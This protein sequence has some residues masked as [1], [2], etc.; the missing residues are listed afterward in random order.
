M[1]SL[2]D[3]KVCEKPKFPFKGTAIKFSETKSFYCAICETEKLIYDVEITVNADGSRSCICSNESCAKQ[4]TVLDDIAPW[5]VGGCD[6]E[7][8]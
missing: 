3:V 6:E 2:R 7:E 4:Q 1:G 5:W 8:D